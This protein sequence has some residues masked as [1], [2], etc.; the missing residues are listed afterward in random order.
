MKVLSICGSPRKKSCSAA[1][2]GELCTALAARGAQLET[3]RLAE[4]DYHGCIACMA[5][6]RTHEQCVVQDD[7][8][9]VLA[10]V[11]A[12][13]VLILSTPVYFGEVTAQLKG[14]IDRTFS[15]LVPDFYDN[16]VK[17]RL[18]PGKKLVF[19][20]TQ[21]HPDP[22]VFGDIFPRY[23]CFMKWYGFDSL[24]LLRVCG[25][26]EPAEVVQRAEVRQRINEIIAAL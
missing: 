18:A 9:D 4:L 22:G 10:A 19:V 20:Q 11:R 12:C 23:E 7:L 2:A 21:G 16:P 14:F 25:T 6:K 24:Q 8:T 5:C 26:E 3:V 15:F 13:D 1:L 17:S